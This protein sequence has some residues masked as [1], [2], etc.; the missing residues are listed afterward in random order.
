MQCCTPSKLD[1]LVVAARA[2]DELAHDVHVAD[3]PGGLL[4]HVD[5]H[6]A[7]RHPLAA[8]VGAE[9]LE[10]ELLDDLV[11]G[12]AGVEGEDFGRGL[13]GVDAQVGVLVI[14]VERELLVLLPERVGEPPVLDGPP[15]A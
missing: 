6:P 7:Q 3:V 14:V 1:A 12:R 5:E 15:D 8:L 10:A 2:V 9:L 4:D 13:A 11:R